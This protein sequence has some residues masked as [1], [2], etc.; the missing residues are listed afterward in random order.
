MDFER[1]MQKA[2]KVIFQNIE[3][4]EDCRV[5]TPPSL[6][7][8]AKGIKRWQKKLY[9]LSSSDLRASSEEISSSSDTPFKKHS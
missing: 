7:C 5:R 9:C 8:P 1:E 6:K 3:A 4:I 2:F